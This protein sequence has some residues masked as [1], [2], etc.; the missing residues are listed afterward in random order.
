M[1]LRKFL[2]MMISPLV[3]LFVWPSLFFQSESPQ[4]VLICAGAFP[5]GDIIHSHLST[6]ASATLPL[7]D[8][9][10]NSREINIGT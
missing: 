1:T 6:S 4:I 3:V 9:L 5:Q 8:N 7:Q 10:V 2:F